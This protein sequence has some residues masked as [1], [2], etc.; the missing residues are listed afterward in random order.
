MPT[1]ELHWLQRGIFPWD[2]LIGFGGRLGT[3]SSSPLFSITEFTDFAHRVVRLK[4]ANFHSDQGL[5][6]IANLAG[7]K[8]NLLPPPPHHQQ[9]LSTDRY[10]RQIWLIYL[11]HN[12]RSTL[13]DR[14]RS[15]G[16][17]RPCSS[18]LDLILLELVGLRLGHW[19]RVVSIAGC[20]IIEFVLSSWTAAIPVNDPIPNPVRIWGR[21]E[22]GIFGRHSGLAE[23]VSWPRAFA[24]R[25]AGSDDGFE[26]WCWWRMVKMEKPLPRVAH[27]CKESTIQSAGRR[28][29]QMEE[30]RQRFFKLTLRNPHLFAD[31]SCFG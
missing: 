12:L 4:C 11:P 3:S 29:I 6:K 22:V 17:H 25:D 21:F 27:K 15:C 5:Y 26:S 1:R 8:L 31:S 9:H 20:I 7:G 18:A 23:L 16:C 2:A 13:L 10:Y 14:S 19:L 24:L 30:T 28:R